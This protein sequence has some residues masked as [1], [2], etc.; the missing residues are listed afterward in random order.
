MTVAFMGASTGVGLA[1]LKRTLAAGHQCVALCR[2][3]SRLT[4]ILSPEANA[5]LRVIQGDAHDVSTVSQLI[6]KDDGSLVDAVV[7]TI[8]AKPSMSAFFDAI[9]VCGKGMV[10]LLEAMDQLRKGGAAGRPYIIACGSTG[11]S[12]FG[13][14]IPL[15]MVPLYVT[16]KKPHEDKKV[17]EAK[18]LESGED[19]TVIRPSFLLNGETN[20][21]IRAGIEDPKKGPES[22]EIG[23]TIS[24][25]DAGKWVAENLVLERK[26]QY[27]N[28]M[29]SITN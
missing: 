1:A 19:F 20:K 29:V 12:K 5:N 15:A 22:K 6:R 28:K 14:D 7:S 9:E 4:A 13:R 16:L 27:I 8:G 25:E 21:K 17:M 18:L 24:R 26:P 23:Y 2:T 3:P 11:M 10:V